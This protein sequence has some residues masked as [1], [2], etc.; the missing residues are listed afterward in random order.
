MWLMFAVYVAKRDSRRWKSYVLQYSGQDSGND[1]DTA[2]EG[3]TDAERGIGE[4]RAGETGAAMMR[5]ARTERRGGLVEAYALE[6]TSNCNR[7]WM[8]RT[9]AG[10]VRTSIFYAV[11]E[12][13]FSFIALDRLLTRTPTARGNG[14]SQFAL[15]IGADNEKIAAVGPLTMV[16]RSRWFLPFS[17][18]FDMALGSDASFLD[19]SSSVISPQVCSSDIAGIPGCACRVDIATMDIAIRSVRRCESEPEC[20][21]EPVNEPEKPESE[22][23]PE[24]A[25]LGIFQVV[26]REREPAMHNINNP[27]RFKFNR[28]PNPNTNPNT[29]SDFEFDSDREEKGDERKEG[30]FAPCLKLNGAWVDGYQYQPVYMYTSGCMGGCIKASRRR[31]QNGSSGTSGPKI[32]KKWDADDWDWDAERR[33]KKGRKVGARTGSGFGLG[34]G[35]KD[36][37]GEKDEQT[38]RVPSPRTMNDD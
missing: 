15:H 5:W 18:S 20:E 1:R 33:R 14:D 17:E 34:H 4:V 7:C 16:P 23:K 32:V 37:R 22:S 31:T 8:H 21:N 26:S 29:I 11:S 28:G 9:I 3:A 36:E 6:V 30:G 10:Q 2:E 19:A 25:A 13:S 24:R 27:A 12:F 38:R 35:L